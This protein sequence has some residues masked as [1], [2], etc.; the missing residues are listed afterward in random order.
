MTN[1]RD[2]WQ[3]ALLALLGAAIVVVVLLP[4]LFNTQRKKGREEILRWVPDRGTFLRFIDPADDGDIVAMSIEWHSEWGRVYPRHPDLPPN[5]LTT[6][7]GT[8][9]VADSR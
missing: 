7:S 8:N 5:V 1:R 3:G 9:R 2:F 4:A 6:V